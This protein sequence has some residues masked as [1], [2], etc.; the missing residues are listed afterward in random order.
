[1]KLF[2]FLLLASVLLSCVRNVSEESVN[3]REFRFR[4]NIQDLRPGSLSRVDGFSEGNKIFLY[5]AKRESADVVAVPA[6]EDLCKMNYGQEGDLTFADGGEHYYPD[7]RIDVY[8]YYWEKEHSEPQELTRMNVSVETDQSNGLDKSDFLYVKAAEGYAK[9]AEPIKLE[10]EHLFSKIVLNIATE[11]PATIDLTQ[12]ENVKLHDVVTSG[13]LN[14]GMGEVENGEAKDEIIMPKSNN[15]SV[16]ILPQEIEGNKKL[17]SFQVAGIEEPFEV[18][19][20]ANNF[21]QGKEYTYNVKVNKYPGM[22]PVEMQFSMLVK[23][24]YSEE[25]YEIVIEKGEEVEVL[26]TEVAVGVNISKADLYLSSGEVKRELKGIAVVDN[27]MKFVFPRLVEGGSL[28]L[29]KAI[30]YT[31]NKESFEYYFENKELRGNNYDRVDLPAPKIGDAWAGGTIFVVGEVTG[32]NETDNEFETDTRG[33]N[34]YR[35]RVVA[36]EGVEELEWCDVRAMGKDKLVGAVDKNDGAKNMRAVKIFI[37]NKG[38]DINKY[39][40]FNACLSKGEEWYFPAINEIKYIVSQSTKLNSNIEAHGGEKIG[41]GNIYGS[42][43]ER[44]E[45]R[46]SDYLRTDGFNV[47][48]NAAIVRAVRAY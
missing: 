7:G 47:K 45:E 35:G 21:E 36:N 37:E 11:T 46:L 17:F 4:S 13:T 10:F 3:G 27:K 38:E 18:E 31:D 22:G 26:L 30:F 33:V 34:A 42:S 8:G 9:D 44:G 25:S 1:M 28:R 15:S 32:Y 5:I 41:D 23:D 12:L 16:I 19:V 39:P 48:D 24:W 2:G 6:S 20:P 14:L 43:T 40:A 29:E